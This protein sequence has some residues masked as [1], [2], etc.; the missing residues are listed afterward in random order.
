MTSDAPVFYLFRFCFAFAF[1]AL[2]CMASFNAA[3]HVLLLVVVLSAS[4]FGC[5]NHQGTTT[6]PYHWW[7]MAPKSFFNMDLLTKN[8][9]MQLY[10]QQCATRMNAPMTVQVLNVRRAAFTR[11]VVSACHQFKAHGHLA[12]LTYFL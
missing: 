8:A 3:T 1:R 5:E 2:A 9:I 10:M 7:T 11:Y 6:R 12:A 4:F